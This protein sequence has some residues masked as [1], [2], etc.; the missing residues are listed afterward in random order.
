MCMHV[1]MGV[2]KYVYMHV[3]VHVC[4]CECVRMFEEG[5]YGMNG[6]KQ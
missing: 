4:A 2:H 6:V 5:D 1:C 3:H